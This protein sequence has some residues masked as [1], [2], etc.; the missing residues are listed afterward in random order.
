MRTTCRELAGQLEVDSLE[1]PTHSLQPR[2]SK[3]A[4]LIKVLDEANHTVPP[5]L[6]AVENYNKP[7]RDRGRQGGGDRDSDIHRGG[8][9]DRGD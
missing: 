4:D 2:T 6:R 8:D 3:A 1:L 5:N 9:R 7:G